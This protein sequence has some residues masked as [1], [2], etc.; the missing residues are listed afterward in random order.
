[1]FRMDVL[2]SVGMVTDDKYK[3]LLDWAF[4]LKLFKAG[5]IGSPCRN[6]TFIVN[7][8]KDDISAGSPEDYHLKRNRVLVDF[9]KP[10]TEEFQ[11]VK[12]MES[13]SRDETDTFQLED[14]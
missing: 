13:Q 14:F 9:V 7:S 11:Q 8:T 10:I 6:A 12:E 5:Y 2:E 3:R 4:L 1:M